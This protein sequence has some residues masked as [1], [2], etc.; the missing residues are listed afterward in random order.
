MFNNELALAD[1]DDDD[2]DDDDGA[3]PQKVLSP[4]ITG[5][6]ETQAVFI[7]AL[8]V[9]QG[10]LQADEL[11][12]L[13]ATFEACDSDTSGGMDLG[14]LTTVLKLWG[15]GQSTSIGL[16]V[17]E[18]PGT[19]AAELIMSAKQGYAKMGGST[20]SEFQALV[21]SVGMPW[22]IDDPDVEDMELSFPEFMHMM[23]SGVRCQLR[24]TV[25]SAARC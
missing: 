17:A 19:V 18:D 10:E 23:V 25:R 22:D 3:P 9:A 15:V 21:D 6:A 4:S 16:A 8:A 2:D 14:E 20:K 11:S 13:R 7:L 5:A 12:D 24:S 1:D